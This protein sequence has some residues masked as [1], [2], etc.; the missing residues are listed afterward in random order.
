MENFEMITMKCVLIRVISG[1]GISK[2]IICMSSALRIWEKNNS[3]EVFS[4]K[5]F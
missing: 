1:T 4:Q 5:F 3:M 2:F